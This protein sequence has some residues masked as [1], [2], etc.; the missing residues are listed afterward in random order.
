MRTKWTG[1]MGLAVV[2]AVALPWSVVRAEGEG[3]KTEKKKEEGGGGGGGRGGRAPSLL[4]VETI[5]EKLGEKLTDEQKKKIGAARDEIQKKNDEI[6]SK[7]DA[8]AAREALS[9][10]RREKDQEAVKAAEAKLKELTGGFNAFEE[11]KKEVTKILGSEEKAT[12][13]F[14]R[15]PGEGRRERGEKGEKKTE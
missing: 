15:K 9:K 10:A 6:F 13:V 11:Y 3:E 1:L 14:A 12:K 7:E 8:K 5:E 4:T 2:L